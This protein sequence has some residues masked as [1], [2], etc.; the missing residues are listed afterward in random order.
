MIPDELIDSGGEPKVFSGVDSVPD[1]GVLPEAPA[2]RV[3]A[4]HVVDTRARKRKP[5]RSIGNVVMIRT[6]PIHSIHWFLG[7]QI[8]RTNYLFFNSLPMLT[9]KLMVDIVF[10]R[11]C[12]NFYNIFEIS[13]IS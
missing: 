7:R 13:K 11:I 4:N 3:T 1:P 8:S 9:L 12:E 5:R 6:K 2:E 10:V